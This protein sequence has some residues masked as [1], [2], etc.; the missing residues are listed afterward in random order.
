MPKNFISLIGFPRSGTTL[1]ARNLSKYYQFAYW[2]E[3]KYIWKYRAR[4]YF[5]DDLEQDPNDRIR[6]YI[7]TRFAK[8][9]G[10]KLF[11]L[12]KTP[13]NIFRIPYLNKLF[14]EMRYIY[15]DSKYPFFIQFCETFFK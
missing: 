6:N 1:I 15:K 4:P 12:E 10:E 5:K 14:P 2:E 3:P 13:S 11:L 9:K 7:L 8:F